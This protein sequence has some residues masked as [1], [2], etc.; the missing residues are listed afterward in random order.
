MK[1]LNT[2]AKAVALV[3]FLFADPFI[4]GSIY[5]GM[6]ILKVSAQCIQDTGARFICMAIACWSVAFIAPFFFNATPLFCLLFAAV[7]TWVY[8]MEQQTPTQTHNSDEKPL[9]A[10]KNDVEIVDAEIV[11]DDP[12]QRYLDYRV[13]DAKQL[14]SQTYLPI[15]RNK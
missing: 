13:S 6:L 11:E 8:A 10:Q 5:I 12:I 4:V 2:L 15:R 7:L 1:H 3:A 14:T 9:A